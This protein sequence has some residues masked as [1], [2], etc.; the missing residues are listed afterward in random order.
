MAGFVHLHNHSE[1]S[2]LDGLSKIPLMVK[3]AKE[4]NLKTNLKLD[5]LEAKLVQM[6]QEIKARREATKKTE[7]KTT[8]K[9]VPAKEETLSQKIGNVKPVSS[10][11]VTETKKVEHVQT[12][13]KQKMSKLEKPK[14][15]INAVKHIEF[16]EQIM[17][18]HPRRKIIVVEDRARPHI[19]KKVDAFVEKRSKRFAVYRLPSYSPE[20]NP[21]EH[22]WEYLKAYQLKAHQAQTTDELRHLV[23][24][25]M[26][27][28]QRK[29]GLVSSFF[30]GSYVM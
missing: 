25:K 18:S 29:K 24:R 30:I 1:Y 27:S 14:E 5:K 15:K 7:T 10:M 2:L 3:R 22:V 23:T 9:A 17:K 28:I 21:D 13:V 6:R 12:S 4:L 19:A 16:L 20:L 26:K 8:E 11:N